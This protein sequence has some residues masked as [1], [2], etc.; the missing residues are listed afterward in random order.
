MAHYLVYIPGDGTANPKKLVQVGLADH[1]ANAFGV[2]TKTGPDGKCGTI[3]YWQHGQQNAYLP[4]LQTWLPA[5]ESGG[6]PADR[7]WVGFQLHANPVPAELAWN[8]PKFEGSRVRLGDGN[9]WEVPAAGML[10]Q[11]FVMRR[12]GKVASEVLPQFKSYFDRSVEWF[13]E[14]VQWD[15]SGAVKPEVDVSTWNYMTD[16]LRLNYRITIEVV[17]H[18]RLFNSQN[19]CHVLCA[20]VEGLRIQADILES[21]QKKSDLCQ[22]VAS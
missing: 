18:C 13:S 3:F 8:Q 2:P 22:A 17:N 1:V 19:I 5:V 16:A 14:C 7:Y 21:H 9:E 20:T 4:D 12:D 15:F 6:L 10:P 11:S